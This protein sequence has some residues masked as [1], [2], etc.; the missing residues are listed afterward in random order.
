MMRNK[1]SSLANYGH[2]KKLIL[3]TMS[4]SEQVDQMTNELIDLSIWTI[5]PLPR[6]ASL[7]T[8]Y[9]VTLVRLVTDR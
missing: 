2:L 9:G 4:G 3:T 5:C 6:L 8:I 1:R 7:S